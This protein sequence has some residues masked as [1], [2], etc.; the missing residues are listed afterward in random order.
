M[1]EAVI[2]RAV[3]LSRT[4]PKGEA[5]AMV[6]VVRPSRPVDGLERKLLQALLRA[7]EALSRARGAMG[8]AAFT[9]GAARQLAEALWEGEDAL[10]QE[11]EGAALAR[12]LLATE[13]EGFDWDAEAIGAMRLLQVKGLERERREHRTRL[14]TA[15]GGEA[16]RLMSEIERISK[17]ILELKQ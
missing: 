3:R 10:A 11:G 9:E 16:D 6:P 8:P 2:A 4:A 12:E 13:T 15:R 17:Q 7:P 14:A 5:P 1:P